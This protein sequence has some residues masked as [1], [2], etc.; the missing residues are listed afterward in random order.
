MQLVSAPPSQG[1]DTRVYALYDDDTRIVPQEAIP[2]GAIL[3]RFIQP[4]YILGGWPPSLSKDWIQDLPNIAASEASRRAEL[5]YTA[6]QQRTAALIQQNN[7]LQ[8]GTDTQTWPASEQN[9]LSE[10]QRG[11]NYITSMNAA[12]DAIVSQTILNPCDDQY[13][14][15]PIDPISLA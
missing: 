5:Y 7:I 14:P 2:A 13:W 1:T 4:Q 15:A 6:A 11:L 3:L 12:K 9:R 10:I 8:Y